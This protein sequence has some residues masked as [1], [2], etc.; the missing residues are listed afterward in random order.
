MDVD[1]VLTDGTIRLDHKGRE[2][3][4][5][6][7]LDS[8]GIA[9]FNK[10]GYSTAIITA[11][12]S[13][14]VT[15]RMKELKINVVYQ[16]AYPKHI[17]YQ[18]MLK[19]LK[20]KDSEVCYMGDDLPDICILKKVGFAVAVKNAVKEVKRSSDYITKNVGGSGA[21]REVVELIMKTQNKWKKLVDA[22]ESKGGV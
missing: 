15:E 7:V 2:I 11:K 9:V 21:A 19:D 4:V 8:F 20:V 16:D 6:N 22:F 18:R 17:A 10:T 3:K 13:G 1:G 14:A 12:S 5:F